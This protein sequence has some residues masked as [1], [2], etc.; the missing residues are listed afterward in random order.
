MELQVINYV[1]LKRYLLEL[2]TCSPGNITAVWL[3]FPLPHVC[4]IVYAV[5]IGAIPVG[6]IWLLQEAT[7]VFW[8]GSSWSLQ[9]FIQM[10]AWCQL[11]ARFTCFICFSFIPPEEIPLSSPPNKN[12]A[13]NLIFPSL[14]PIHTL[15]D[16]CDIHVPVIS[17]LV[18][19]C[20]TVISLILYVYIEYFS[21]LLFP[22]L[23]HS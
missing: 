6:N 19:N 15:T 21:F 4:T 2:K 3:H 9:F 13:S 14:A 22:V 16:I 1:F 12:I 5:Q 8:L 18:G 17:L 10:S 23:L 7:G 20:I 11:V